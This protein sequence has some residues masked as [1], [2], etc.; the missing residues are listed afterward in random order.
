MRATIEVEADGPIL[1]DVFH[2]WLQEFCGAFYSPYNPLEGGVV[3]IKCMTF[4]DDAP[5]S[6]RMTDTE[7]AAMAKKYGRSKETPNG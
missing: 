4:H 1:P 7:W 3:H 2:R 5:V 6:L